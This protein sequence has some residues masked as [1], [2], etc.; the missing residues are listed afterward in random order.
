MLSRMT[1]RRALWLLG[2]VTAALFLA[3]VIVDRRMQDTGGP[4]IIP[5]ELAGSAE[6]AAEILAE[7][8]EEGQDAARLSLWIDFPY[9]LA[10]GAFFSLAVIAMRDAAR[11]RGWHRYARPGAAIAVLPIVAAACDAVENVNLLLVLDGDDGSTAP[12]LATGFAIAK[13]ASLAVVQLYLLAGLIALAKAR[14][15]GRH[16]ATGVSPSS[17]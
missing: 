10:Y 1:R 5:F 8:G 12:A 16:Q 6:R 17:H 13:L 3:L 14:V 11:R 15:S 4:G 2:I 9:L 7:W